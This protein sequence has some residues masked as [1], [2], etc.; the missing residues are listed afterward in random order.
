MKLLIFC[1][2]LCSTTVILANNEYR[3]N[4]DGTYTYIGKCILHEDYQNIN[5]T[6][7]EVIPYTETPSNE[8]FTKIP[9]IFK[10]LATFV[11]NDEVGPYQDSTEFDLEGFDDISFDLIKL[12]DTESILHRV[13]YG[14]GG[15]NG[16]YQIF[17]VDSTGKA[18]LLASTFDSDVTFCAKEVLTN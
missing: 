18:K 15:G 9:T 8:F 5:F 14:V 2:L 17:K 10:M 4:E 1:I 16:G 12:K 13:S 6:I 3:E 11:Y 7:N